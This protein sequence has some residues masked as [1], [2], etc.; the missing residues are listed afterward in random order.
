MAKSSSIAAAK[1]VEFLTAPD[2]GLDFA[3]AQ[4]AA[5]TG[6]ALE[7]VP[8]THIVS[9]NVAFEISEKSV[10]VKYPVVHV[11]VDRVR[12]LLTEKFRTFSGKIRTVVEVRVSQDRFEGIEDQL[13]IYIDAVTQVLDANRGSWDQGLFFNGGYEITFEPVRRGGRNL[14]QSAKVTFEVDLSS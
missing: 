14:L 1:V 10:V 3:I 12:N 8:P 6:A 4:V 2:G 5:D 9:Q 13:R 7:R 11:Y